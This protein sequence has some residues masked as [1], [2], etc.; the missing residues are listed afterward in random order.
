MDDDERVYRINAVKLFKVLHL[1]RARIVCADPD[2]DP[3]TECPYYDESAPN[4][5]GV[6]Y[7]RIVLGIGDEPFARCAGEDE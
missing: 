5:C 6:E 4:N 7:L 1:M 2:I 3:P